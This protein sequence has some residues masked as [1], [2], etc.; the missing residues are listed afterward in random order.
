MLIKKNLIFFPGLEF[1][2]L[3]EFA[4]AP[5]K[6]SIIAYRYDLR[7][8]YNDIIPKC[9]KKLIKTDIAMLLPENCYLRIAPRSG[10][11]LDYFLTVWGGV[12]D[13]DYRGSLY[14]L[15]FNRSNNNFIIYRRDKNAQ[16]NFEKICDTFLF[17]INSNEYSKYQT[18]RGTKGFGSTGL[19]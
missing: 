15:L 14:V 11:A 17:Y 2:I 8:V 1:V 5:E 12:I 3:S 6:S 4:Y 18:V 9:D 10:L 16:F 7:S 19:Q 13:P